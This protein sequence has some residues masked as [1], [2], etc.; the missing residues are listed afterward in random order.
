MSLDR[1]HC[2]N[3]AAP[4]HTLLPRGQKLRG[5][6]N[7][8]DLPSIQLQLRQVVDILIRDLGLLL[9][10]G[11]E[12]LPDLYPRLDAQV[13]VFQGDVDAR[14]ESRVDVVHTVRRHE[15]DA[16]IVLEGP[17]ENGHDLVPLEVVRGTSLEEDIALIEEKDGVPAGDELED[18]REAVFNLPGLRA[19]ITG[20]E[21][22]EWHAE[23][24]CNPLC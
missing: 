17:Q 6:E 22:V 2:V 16:F 10:G 18:T 8:L 15:Q 13:R 3:E 24:F 5:L 9:E 7:V 21:G 4:Q 14:L 1:Q 19:Q 23:M 11:E 20:A 12:V